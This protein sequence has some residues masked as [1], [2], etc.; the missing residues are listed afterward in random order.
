M[1]RTPFRTEIQVELGPGT[2]LSVF[3]G[4]A[5]PRSKVAGVPRRRPARPTHSGRSIS[6]PRPRLD[7]DP[8]ALSHQIEIRRSRSEDTVSTWFFVKEPPSFL[9]ST[10]SPSLFKNNCS[11][12]QNLASS[13]LSFLNIEPAVQVCCFCELDPQSFSLITF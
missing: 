13:P 5:P 3:S 12:A 2:P 9:I 10:R 6:N 11:L 4:E 7:L 8:S 1:T